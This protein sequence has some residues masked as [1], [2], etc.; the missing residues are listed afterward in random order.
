MLESFTVISIIRFSVKER[1]KS[2]TNTVVFKAI[3]NCSVQAA[4]IRCVVWQCAK[5]REYKAVVR[6]VDWIV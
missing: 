1:G 5:I 4:W 3:A 2:E 6:V